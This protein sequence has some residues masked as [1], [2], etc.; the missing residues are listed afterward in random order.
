MDPNFIVAVLPHP[1]LPSARRLL[2]FRCL[3]LSYSWSHLSFPRFFW[4]N[5]FFSA[6]SKRFL[7][8][9]ILFYS[10]VNLSDFLT[11]SYSSPESEDQA[12]ASLSTW[13][14]SSRA[15]NF[16]PFF[17]FFEFYWDFSLE[18]GTDALIICLLELAISPSPSLDYNSS[19]AVF[20]LKNNS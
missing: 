14:K 13:F 6:F 12:F 4:T 1:W 2:V 11:P 20:R 18:F 16:G 8:Y 3:P 9:F 17:T 5:Y 15:V 7:S 10:L 19:S